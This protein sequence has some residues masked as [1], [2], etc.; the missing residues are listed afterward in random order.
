MNHEK[1]VKTGQFLTKSVLIVFFSYGIFLRM[2]YSVDSYMTFYETNANIHLKQSRYLNYCVETLLL[3]FDINPV[4]YQALFTTILIGSLGWCI[5]RLTSYA[6]SMMNP[7]NR[8]GLRCLTWVVVSVSFINVF[9][10]EWFLYPEITL[11]YSCAIVCAVEAVIVLSK[12]LRLINYL[13]AFFFIMLS[14]FSYQAALS[15]FVIYFLTFSLIKNKF[16]L[17]RQFFK[18]TGTGLSVGLLGSI[19][20]IICQKLLDAGGGR[21]A[22][23]ELGHIVLNA[24]NL[25]CFQ[26]KLW[27][28]QLG[29]WPPFVLIVVSS[30]ISIFLI[31][32]IR[33]VCAWWGVWGIGGILFINYGIIFAPHLFTQKLWLAQRT[34]VGFWSFLSSIGLLLC[35]ISE[36]RQ[37]KIIHV[38]GFLVILAINVILIWQIGGNHFRSNK[39]DYQYICEIQTMIENYERSSGNKISYISICRDSAFQ[40]S[41]PDIDYVYGDTN[42]RCF[43]VDWGTISAINYYTARNYQKKPMDSQIY[44]QYFADKDWNAFSEEQ[45]VFLG[46]TLFLCIY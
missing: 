22:N 42:T 9:I 43:S 30:I 4:V 14:L 11:Y 26:N 24:W 36:K 46:N 41:Y 12:G 45:F 10:L 5:A 35:A 21:D 27:M 19:L 15:V 32:R 8:P 29:F 23:L 37:E 18:E 3:H 13:L 17:N 6:Q 40:Y 2:H 25:L 20:L 16:Q 31:F 38:S 7:D 44:N 33:K 1:P 28:N 34:I 39:G